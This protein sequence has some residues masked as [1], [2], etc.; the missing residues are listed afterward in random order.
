MDNVSAFLGL[1][2]KAGKLEVGEEPVGASCRAKKASLVIIA[3]DAAENSIRRA[4][5]YAEAGK[6]P[7]LPV[8]LDKGQL[9]QAIGK[10]PCAM[11]SITDIGFS[12]ALAKKLVA[13]SPED[14]ELISEQLAQKSVRVMQRRKEK[15]AHEKK[16]LRGKKKP[17]LSR[18]EGEKKS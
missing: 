10:P 12:A 6:V 17:R 15:Q 13:V 7:I 2:K 3:S 14:G 4:T 9:G 8:S 16:L 5:H 11:I 18:I 1:I